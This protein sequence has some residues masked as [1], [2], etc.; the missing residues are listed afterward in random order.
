M[1]PLWTVIAMMG[2]ARKL[3]PWL[4][5]VFLCGAA[6]L[7]ALLRLAVLPEFRRVRW[8]AFVGLMALT[9]GVPLWSARCCGGTGWTRRSVQ[10]SDVTP[11]AT[12]NRP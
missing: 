9:L 3:V 4:P 1:L 11:T 10:P 5:L 6:A 2:R 7:F 12:S 8:L